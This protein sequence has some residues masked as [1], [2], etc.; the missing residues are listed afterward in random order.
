[1]LAHPHVRGTEKY[2][3]KNPNDPCTSVA[4]T[5][6]TPMLTPVNNV[7]NYHRSLK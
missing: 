1:M 2:L 7:L 4:I 5:V 3:H 6:R